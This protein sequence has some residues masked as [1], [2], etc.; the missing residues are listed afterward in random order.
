MNKLYLASAALVTAL[1]LTGPASAADMPL[2]AL[3]PPPVPVCIWCGWYIGVNVGGAWG[4]A[5][6]TFTLNGLFAQDPNA[7]FFDTIGSPRFHKTS[8]TGGGQIG[9]NSQWGTNWV[10][11]SESDIE[12]IGLKGSRV[13]TF[14]GKFGDPA[15]VI[16]F[17]ESVKDQWVST[18]RIRIGYAQNNWL[19]YGTVGIAV[20]RVQLSQFISIPNFTAGGGL[21]PEFNVAVAS[22][23][24]V[25]KYVGGFAGGGGLEWK[26]SPNWS[27]R[28]EDIYIDFGRRSDVAFDAAVVCTSGNGTGLCPPAPAGFTTRHEVHVF[29]NIARFALNYQFPVAAPV[30][31]AIYK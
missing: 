9:W 29:T 14:T 15:E 26:L 13:A 7:P 22:G 8:V 30:A 16:T 1:T 11:G 12:Y 10:V 31:P 25:S 3:P 17:D 18:S 19:L 4:S 23:G 2:K 24:S 28:G 27:I 5:E 6:K 21:E 20:S